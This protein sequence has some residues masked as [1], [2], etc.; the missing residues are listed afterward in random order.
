[1]YYHINLNKGKKGKLK[2]MRLKIYCILLQIVL[3]STIFVFKKLF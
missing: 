3:V 1:V 2:M